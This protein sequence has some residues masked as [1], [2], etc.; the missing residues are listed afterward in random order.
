MEKLE[1]L[2]KA[3]NVN[4]RL[5]MAIGPSFQQLPKN[6]GIGGEPREDNSTRAN[7]RVETNSRCE[8]S[9]R[10]SNRCRNLNIPLFRLL[11][12]KTLLKL[13]ILSQS[14]FQGN[15]RQ[16]MICMLRLI[17]ERT[18]ADYWSPCL[19][20]E[21]GFGLWMAFQEL[22]VSARDWGKAAGFQPMRWIARSRRLRFALINFSAMASGGID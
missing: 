17:L 7:S 5:W 12:S 9:G 4:P 10:Q 20:S 18:I 14:N 15:L 22:F 21:A 16:D 6:V 1:R 11:I 8:I 19:K 3:P 13:S 2:R